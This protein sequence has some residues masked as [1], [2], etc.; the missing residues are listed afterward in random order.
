VRLVGFYLDHEATAQHRYM[1]GV[2]IAAVRRC[3]PD[4][5]ILHMTTPQTEPLR[6]ADDV[7]M[8]PV[9]GHAWVRRAIVQAHAPAPILSLDVDVFMRRPVAELWEL[10]CDVAMP[11]ITDP[12]VRNTGGVWFCRSPAL[13]QAWAKRV[14]E[15]D[16]TDVRALLIALSEHV[17]RWPGKIVRLPESKYE[18][19][20][21]GAHGDFG[22]AS[23]VHYRGPRKRWFPGV[24]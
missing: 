6:A 1:A 21:T 9:A 16:P 12:A 24:A 3:M 13:W 4:A 2:S 18:R 5:T 11:D 22:D 17:D 14:T 7:M 15:I 20:P 19:L 23:L 8:V 10:D